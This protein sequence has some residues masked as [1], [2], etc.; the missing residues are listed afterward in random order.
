MAETIGAA[1]SACFIEL[2]AQRFHLSSQVAHVAPQFVENLVEHLPLAF[3]AM[4]LV[5]GLRNGGELG[6]FLI[7]RDELREGFEIDFPFPAQH[8]HLFGDVLELSHVAWPLIF[9][10]ERLGILGE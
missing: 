6:S 2:V 8:R 5:S 10:H 4:L 7:S 9:Q 3:V 1:E